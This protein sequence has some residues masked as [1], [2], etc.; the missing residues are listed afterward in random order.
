M[1]TLTAVGCYV[2]MS[3]LTIIDLIAITIGLY[4]L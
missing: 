2:L 4:C 3:F 1:T